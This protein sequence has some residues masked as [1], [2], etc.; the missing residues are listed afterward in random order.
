MTGKILSPQISVCS[1]VLKLLNATSAS[2]MSPSFKVSSQ[3]PGIKE[4]YWD[5]SLV[6]LSTRRVSTVIPSMLMNSVAKVTSAESLASSFMASSLASMLWDWI[7]SIS[8]RAA[9]DWQ[10]R[11]MVP[12]TE[13]A[14]AGWVLPASAF[15]QKP[16]GGQG[17]QSQARDSSK[18]TFSS[19]SQQV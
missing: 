4:T 8:W 1:E 11:G 14:P 13:Q 19:C 5:R 10:E 6:P 15:C 17:E 16:M 12:V 9:L 2:K 3:S 18:V 7:L